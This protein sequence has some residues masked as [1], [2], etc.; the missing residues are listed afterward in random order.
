MSVPFNSKNAYQ[1]KDL[2]RLNG[3]KWDN[4]KKTWM[5]PPKSLTE[6]NRESA[7]LDIKAQ[8]LWKEAC[9]LAGVNFCK[10]GTPEYERVKEIFKT[11]IVD[12]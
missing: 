5:V 8:N 11:M 7:K 3:G 10:K 2:I 6:L 4:T 1:L 9:Q 12:A